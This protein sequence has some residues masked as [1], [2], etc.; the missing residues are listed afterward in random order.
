MANWVLDLPG[1]D[2]QQ[3]CAAGAPGLVPWVPDPLS[4]LVVPQNAA[5]APV[6]AHWMQGPLS[7]DEP[8]PPPVRTSPA[9]SRV[10]AIP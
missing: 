10:V 1:A 3:R 2:E 8:L 5:G 6:V 7:V 4:A 9:P